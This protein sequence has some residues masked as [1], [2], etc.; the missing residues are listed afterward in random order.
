[1]VV[2]VV[3]LD[4]VLKVIRGMRLGVGEGSGQGLLGSGKGELFGSVLGGVGGLDR[5]EKG[6]GLGFIH[7]FVFGTEVFVVLIRLHVD[8]V[9]RASH[10]NY[11]LNDYNQINCKESLTFTII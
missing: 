6:S 10:L 8:E 4:F 11:N 7:G 5:V 3:Q 9:F 2:D 1:V